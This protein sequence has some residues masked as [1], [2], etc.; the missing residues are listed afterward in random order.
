MFIA[1]ARNTNGILTWAQSMALIVVA[2]L[3]VPGCGGKNAVVLSPAMHDLGVVWQGETKTATLHLSN[4]SEGN[5]SV[6][7]IEGSCKC[8]DIA[9]DKRDLR[10]GEAATITVKFVGGREAAQ[11][12]HRVHVKLAD[13]SELDAFVVCEVRPTVRVVDAKSTAI[14]ATTDD[15]G[16]GAVGIL[17]DK[18][19]EEVRITL[20]RGGFASVV[21]ESLPA[22][23]HDGYVRYLARVSIPRG[24]SSDVFV[25][26]L[27]VRAKD[28]V[29]HEVPIQI[30]V[31]SEVAIR[32][33]EIFFGIGARGVRESCNV[34]VRKG[35][36]TVRVGRAELSDGTPGMAEVQPDGAG[37]VIVVD[38]LPVG[39]FQAPKVKSGALKL[40]C[41]G[42]PS[43]PL[44]VPVT[45]VAR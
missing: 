44:I 34:I 38:E 20:A 43:G 19:T 12:A 13:G 22:E 23:A 14:S 26:H 42:V 27:Q 29:L 10:P 39:E 2:S 7:S 9:I 5:V 30:A 33:A 11:G 24:L 25:D 6:R 37:V 4:D 18:R 1:R 15:G 35:N 3:I 32:P 21:T 45:W 28:K 31:R 17:V 8:Q 36:A 41:E 40:H 16:S